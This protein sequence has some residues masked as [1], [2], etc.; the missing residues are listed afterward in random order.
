M[1]YHIGPPCYCALYSL[2]AN[3]LAQLSFVRFQVPDQQPSLCRHTLYSVRNRSLP[4]L[5]PAFAHAS[6]HKPPRTYSTVQLQLQVE[7]G[8][9]DVIS[10]TLF[11][12]A[13]GGK[14]KVSSP[15]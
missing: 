13:L 10:L 8:D 11:S 4:L 15:L 14:N 3:G 2:V 1:L 6:N 5:G 7:R 9:G 12:G